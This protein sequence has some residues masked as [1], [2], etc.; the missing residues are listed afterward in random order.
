[1]SPG[2]Q[3]ARAGGRARSKEARAGDTDDGTLSGVAFSDAFD[4]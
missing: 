2:P 3:D 1:L 4:E